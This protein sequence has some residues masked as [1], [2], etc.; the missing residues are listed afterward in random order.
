MKSKMRKL[1][2]EELYNLY[3]TSNVK[4]I[5][6]KKYEISGACTGETTDTY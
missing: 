3:S 2:N 1:H 5:K 4:M 6:I